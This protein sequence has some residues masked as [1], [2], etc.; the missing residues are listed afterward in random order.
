M[1]LFTKKYDKFIFKIEQEIT[2]KE[3]RYILDF[4]LKNVRFYIIHNQTNNFR[5]LY[6]TTKKLFL[7]TEILGKTLFFIKHSFDEPFYFRIK[8]DLFNQEILNYNQKKEINNQLFFIPN[9]ILIKEIYKPDEDK[10]RKEYVTKNTFHKT[11]IVIDNHLWFNDELKKFK[12]KNIQNKL[13]KKILAGAK[14]DNRIKK[15]LITEF[16]EIPQIFDLENNVSVDYMKNQS[17]TI[18]LTQGST[19]KSSILGMLSNELTTTSDAGM[20]GYY[21]VVNGNWINGEVSKTTKSIFVDEVNEL[22]KSNIKKGNSILNTLNTPLENGKYVYGKAGGRKIF[23]GNQFI[24]SGNIEENFHFEMFVNGLA[25]NQSTLGR[26]FCYIIYDDKLEFKNGNNRDITKFNGVIEPIKKFLSNLLLYYLK[27]K[28]FLDK[29]VNNNKV[30]NQIRVKYYREFEKIL[31]DIEHINTKQFLS[32]FIQYSL[33][34]RLPIMA[35]KLSL[36]NYLDKF[37]ELKDI[38]KFQSSILMDRL[39]IEY[40]DLLKD[41]IISF[42]N[43]LTHQQI[44]SIQDNKNEL[45]INQLNKSLPRTYLLLLYIIGVEYKINNYNMN[46]IDY[47]ILEYKGKLKYLKRDILKRGLSK[48]IQMLNEFGVYSYIQGD[49]LLFRVSKELKNIFEIIDKNMLND[50]INYDDDLKLYLEKKG[51]NNSNKLDDE[52]VEMLE[53][54]D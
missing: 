8:K 25:T 28:N 31:N 54:N 37:L 7:N 49:K 34:N 11:R 2:V 40:E 9:D 4:N 35:L 10:P 12:L 39:Y 36:F 47:N 18:I 24:F 27:N 20:F 30:L 15:V 44:Y 53:E 33:T 23:F 51:V 6:I 52:I 19:G 50:L 41:L 5:F 22:I 42:K 14:I 29:N 13:L 3:S 26:R 45:L 17:H 43:I 1:E 32:S 21:D 46:V 38:S 48:N 16:F